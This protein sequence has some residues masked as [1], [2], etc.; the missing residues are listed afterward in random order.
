[1]F[2]RLKEVDEGAF[3]NEFIHLIQQDGSHHS[4][5]QAFGAWMTR[6]S[7]NEKDA[8][9]K[10]V[11]SLAAM[12]ELFQEPKRVPRNISFWSRT[13]YSTWAYM[14]TSRKWVQYEE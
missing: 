4:V 9:D 14:K 12:K 8:N 11:H 10:I 7:T 5:F 2:D 3:L 13:I 1:V 6:G